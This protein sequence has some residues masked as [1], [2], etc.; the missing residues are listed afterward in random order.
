MKLSIEK[1]LRLRES[2]PE[3]A[4]V[5]DLTASLA[6]FILKTLGNACWS[7]VR[8]AVGHKCR[9]RSWIKRFL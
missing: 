6:T 9:E 8:N 4:G 2:D 7:D 5:S 1:G 3:K